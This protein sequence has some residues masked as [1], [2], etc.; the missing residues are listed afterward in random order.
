MHNSKFMHLINRQLSHAAVFTD[1]IM[2]LLISAPLD[3]F[4]KLFRSISSAAGR[5]GEPA[6]GRRCHWMGFGCMHSTWVDSVK[7]NCFICRLYRGV[8]ASEGEE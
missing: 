4:R 2:Y 7:L 6:D 1:D 8:Q 3:E 5:G